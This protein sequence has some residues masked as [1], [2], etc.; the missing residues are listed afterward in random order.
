MHRRWLQARNQPLLPVVVV[1][2]VA[3]LA[4]LFAC[5]AQSPIPPD[6]AD[7]DSA[8]DESRSGPPWI[9]GQ[10]DARFTI[11]LYADFACAYCRSYFPVLKN[12]ISSHPE[13]NWQWHHLP[14]SA[15]V[16]DS[17]KAARVAECAG[18]VGGNAAFWRAAS[19]IYEDG[20]DNQTISEAVRACLLSSRPHL[21]IQAQAAAAEQE[22]ITGTPTLKVIDRASGKALVL[23]GPVEGD[24]LLSAIDLLSATDAEDPP[25]ETP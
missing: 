23:H 24:A 19:S 15:G 3:A 6:V 1:A 12:W 14:G 9:Y 7:S 8:T 20:L 17:L 5:S 11:V 2:S 25:S 16:P 13:A 21:L 10:P 18:E 22:S 4:A